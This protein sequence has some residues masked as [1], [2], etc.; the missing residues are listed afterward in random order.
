M[1][2]PI[3]KAKALEIYQKLSDSRDGVGPMN[4]FVASDGWLWRF[5]KRHGIRQLNLQGEKLSADKPAADEFVVEFR[6]FVRGNYTLDQIFNCDES[7]LYY[8]MLPQ[9]TLASHFEKSADGR[10]SQKERVTINAC[11]NASGTIKL[12]LLLI[13]KSK[14]PR[15][16]KHISKDSLPV[17]YMNQSNAWVD[18]A[19]FVSWFQKHFVPNV[20]KQ[21]SE[22]GVE[23]KAVLV[24]DNCS[25]HP[26][27]DNLVSD[28]GKIIA[29]FLPPNVTSL[30]QP[31]DQGVLVSIKRRYRKKFLEEFILR[32]DEGVSIIDFL[33]SINML[34]V[35]HLIACAWK[36]ILPT[37]LQLSW[38]KILP[39]AVGPETTISV[40]NQSLTEPSDGVQP[41]DVEELHS[42]FQ[43]AGHDLSL[44]E[45]NNWI[46]CDGNDKGY[47][48]LSDDEI[49]QCLR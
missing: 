12:P 18:T 8:K 23:Q 38:R 31:M 24:L 33:K 41:A 45:V 34:Q 6:D 49:V 46:Q 27:E 30:I 26:G 44:G 22:L 25:A 48:H 3:L 7:G 29:K 1:T 39:H 14:N 20:R 13:G 35:V 40:M 16:F 15:C 11:S 37:T 21:L 28:D 47:S 32:D 5:S 4:K 36:E 2:G 19:I 17:V 9:K 43:E 42:M 10:K